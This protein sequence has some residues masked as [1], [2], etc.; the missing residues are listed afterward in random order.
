MPLDLPVYLH[1]HD[2]DRF[3]EA[4]ADESISLTV[5]WDALLTD[6]RTNTNPL[7]FEMAKNIITLPVDQYTN[8]EQIEYLLAQLKKSLSN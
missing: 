2:R 5:H 7:T 3:L 8:G 1:G 4:L 6:P